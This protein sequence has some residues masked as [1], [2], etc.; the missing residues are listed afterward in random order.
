MPR[1]DLK[2]HLD[3][4]R[5]REIRMPFLRFFE[6]SFGRTWEKEAVLV[7][8][9]AEGICGWGECVAGEGPFFSYEDK[10]TAW[11]VLTRYLVPLIISGG[12]LSAVEVPERLRRIRGHPMAKAALECAVWDLEARLRGVPLWSL[13]GGRRRRIPCGVSIGIQDEPAALLERIEAEL[14]AGYQRIKIKIRPGW[15]L[16]IVEL[17]RRRFP[18]V[19]LMVD[20][21]AAYTLPDLPRLKELDRFHL[22]MIEQP[23]AH[24]DLLQHARLQQELET[25]L[26]LDESIRHRGDLELALELGACRILNLKPGRV[27]GPSETFRLH[28]LARERGIGLWCG[29]M[30][31]TG[32]GR[33]HN[34]ALST[35]EHFQLPGD[36]SASN[37]YF[38]RDT[39]VPPVEVRDGWIDPPESP[40]LGFEPDRDWIDRI[41]VRSVCLNREGVKV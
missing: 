35:L 32:I 12:P 13:Y 23:L 36:V 5:L 29:G 37:R 2:F 7:E 34:V 16:A 6:T 41:T 21:N 8:V 25:P 38:H 17:V 1:H 18:D 31:E 9:C 15:D 40:G 19:P 22:M 26:C 28:D 33:A 20:A 10:D 30:L 11:H 3:W 27:G 14:A 24:D 4:V 39:I